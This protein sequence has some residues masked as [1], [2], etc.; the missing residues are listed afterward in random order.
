[1]EGWD[2]PAEERIAMKRA[3]KPDAESATHGQPL[4]PVCKQAAPPLD[5]Q[6]TPE[7]VLVNGNVITLGDVMTQ[8]GLM[9]EDALAVLEALK[10]ET[11]APGDANEDLDTHHVDTQMTTWSGPYYS[12]VMALSPLTKTLP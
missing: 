7:Q 4:A 3:S 5:S 1:M 9:R 12:A 8:H 2:L 11:Q 10:A 6:L